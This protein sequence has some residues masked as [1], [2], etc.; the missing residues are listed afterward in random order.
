[1]KRSFVI[2]CFDEKSI[3]AAIRGVNDREEWLKQKVDELAGKLADLGAVSASLGFSRAF[4]VGPNDVSVT[5][6]NKGSGHY[7]VKANGESVLFIEFGA[8]VRYGY[9]HPEPN[10]YGPGTYPGKGHWDDP[11]G[12]YLPKSAQSAD[13]TKHSYGNPPAM[14]M[15]NAVKE[16]EQNLESIVREVFRT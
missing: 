3:D 5:V 16:L 14:A 8:G 11:N 10:G 2:D 13:G 12:W 15:Y 4:Y 9:G 1:M 7:V 6:E